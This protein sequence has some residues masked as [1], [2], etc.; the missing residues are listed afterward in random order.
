MI[1]VNETIESLIAPRAGLPH[2]ILATQ[3][4]SRSKLFSRGLPTRKEEEW[5]Y[6]PSSIFSSRIYSTSHESKD[7][8]SLKLLLGKENLPPHTFVFLNGSYVPAFTKSKDTIQFRSVG[9][10]EADWNL[11]S[12]GDSSSF[13]DLLSRSSAGG[14]FILDIPKGISAEV[15]MIHVTSD[16][17]TSV[18]SSNRNLIR[19]GVDSQLK[20]LEHHVSW[21]TSQHL[22]IQN[23]VVQVL[24]RGSFEHYKLQHEGLG[25]HHISKIE[26]TVSGDANYSHFLFNLESDYSRDEIKISLSEPGAKTHLA[27]LYTG[28]GKQHHE[29]MIQIDHKAKNC[30]SSQFFKGLLDDSSTG[31][32]DGSVFVAP[33]SAGTQAEQLNKNL[34]LS[35]NAQA[36]T[37]PQLK[38]LAD[39]VK[40][41][42]GA[43][44]GEID[45]QSLFYLQSRGIPKPKAVEILTSAYSDE[46]VQLVKWPQA[47][48]RIQNS[49]AQWITRKESHDKTI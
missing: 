1:P 47:K 45:K 29:Q 46:I 37:K 24:E 20:L 28:V 49:I 16:G 38:I 22:T 5:R 41:T 11:V 9:L 40:C 7:T 39:D 33:G 4:E 15:L 32:F 10:A 2:W 19:V 27:G 44:T 21:N 31:V 14:G 30:Q 3:N 6:T 48:E 36:F 13:T 12:S 8:N 42:H 35:P 25:A 26:A 34:L 18:A 17:E 43:T 23:T